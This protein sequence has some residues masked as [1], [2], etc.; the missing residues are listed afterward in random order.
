LELPIDNLFLIFIDKAKQCQTRMVNTKEVQYLDF[1]YVVKSIPDVKWQYMTPDVV[2]NRI[3]QISRAN[4]IIRISVPEL[5]TSRKYDIL[6]DRFN[7]KGQL[8]TVDMNDI[9][10]QFD[11]VANANKRMTLKR[12]L[13]DYLPRWF[14]RF[15]FKVLRT[16]HFGKSSPF[17]KA[18]KLSM[19]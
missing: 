9:L 5:N 8:D 18:V 19:K 12:E 7:E 2:Y 6:I 10:L 16:K 1:G 11:G 17:G 13:F 3:G 15:C 14:K 4:Q